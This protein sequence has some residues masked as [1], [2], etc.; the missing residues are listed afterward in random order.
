MTPAISFTAHLN[1]AAK[2]GNPAVEKAGPARKKSK[3]R[4]A[5]PSKWKQN[6]QKQLRMEGKEYI[7]KR[8]KD[9]ETVVKQP[10]EMG[11]RCTSSTC[12]K[13]SNRLCSDITEETRKRLFDEFWQHMN[14]A[15]RKVYVAGLVDREPVERSRAVGAQSRRSVSL[16]YHLMVDGKRKQVCKNMFLSTL[17]VGEW[18]VLNWSQKGLTKK[19]DSNENK[20]EKKQVIPP[21]PQLNPAP[22]VSNTE[23]KTQEGKCFSK[24]LYL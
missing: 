16:R 3:A 14:W 20:V 18:S 11:S 19:S 22:A 13:V 15:Q 21:C 10:R 5:E 6:K 12:K 9:G 24:T 23:E 1:T 7:S 4:V 17:G 8:K 2:N